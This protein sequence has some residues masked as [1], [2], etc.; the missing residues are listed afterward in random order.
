VK[1]YVSSLLG[2]LGFERRT[3]AAVYEIERRGRS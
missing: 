3:Q 2:K 1:T